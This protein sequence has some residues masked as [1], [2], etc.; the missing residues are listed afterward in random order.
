MR[1][2]KESFERRVLKL[3]QDITDK[4]KSHEELLVEFR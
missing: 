1:E 4:T 2:L 3:E